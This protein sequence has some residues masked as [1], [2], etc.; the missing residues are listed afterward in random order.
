MSTNIGVKC[1]RIFVF[2]KPSWLKRFPAAHAPLT[3]TI[4]RV[5]PQ[6]VEMPL[7]LVQDVTYLLPKGERSANPSKY[8]PITCLPTLYK[9][10]TAWG[11]ERVY[12]RFETNHVILEQQKVRRTPVAARNNR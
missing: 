1:L 11:A 2:V 12:R 3:A 10:I 4:N 9:V 5:L 8:G 6:P 7:F